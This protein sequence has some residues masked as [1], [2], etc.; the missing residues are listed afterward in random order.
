MRESVQR[1]LG[2]RREE[3]SG[4]PGVGGDEARISRRELLR[5][6][7]ATGASLALAACTPRSTSSASSS[8]SRT[9]PHDARVVIVGAG[10]AGVTAAY[11]LAAQG[12]NVRLFE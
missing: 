9:T 7:G 2:V 10:L 5:A 11:R 6:A 12:V 8:P 3:A 4:S 1:E